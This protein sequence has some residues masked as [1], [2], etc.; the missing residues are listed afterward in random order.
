MTCVLPQYPA[1][2]CPPELVTTTEVGVPPSGG[3]LPDTG[4]AFG[5]QLFVVAV[6]ALIIGLM[7]VFSAVCDR[8]FRGKKPPTPEQ[9]KA[10]RDWAH[11]Q[12]YDDTLR[13]DSERVV[14]ESNGGGG[15]P[16]EVVIED[17]R[18]RG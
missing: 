13:A 11:Q 8:R 4:I 7:L 6:V 9:G 15:V 14:L 12:R 5:A 17:W 16:R 10:S 2:G 18:R 1:G 3:E